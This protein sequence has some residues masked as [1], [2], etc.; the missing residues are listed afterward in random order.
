MKWCMENVVPA[1]RLCGAFADSEKV[2]WTFAD[3][4]EK[5]LCKAFAHRAKKS[6][7]AW[8]SCRL[9]RHLLPAKPRTDPPH[10]VTHLTHNI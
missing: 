6:K 1:K 4:K 3:S 2:C 5:S 10:S 7:S 8:H 9:I